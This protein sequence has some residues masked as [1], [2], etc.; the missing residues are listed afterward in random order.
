MRA[1]FFFDH[2]INIIRDNDRDYLNKA[3]M[4]KFFMVIHS[5]VERNHQDEFNTDEDY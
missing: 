1:N 3:E 4:Y 2:F 5:V